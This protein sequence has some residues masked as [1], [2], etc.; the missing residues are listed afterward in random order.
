MRATSTVSTAARGIGSIGERRCTP[1]G[2]HHIREK[3]GAGT[4]AWRIIQERT[5]TGALADMAAASTLDLITSRILWLD[6]LEPGVN[7]G[8]AMHGHDRHIHFRGAADEGPIGT[9]ASRGC[10]CMRRSSC[11]SPKKAPAHWC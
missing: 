6:G 5:F 8:A 2:L 4:P 7:R 11:C 10:V 3:P 1:Q 9:P